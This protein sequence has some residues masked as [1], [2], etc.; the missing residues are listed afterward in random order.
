VRSHL[1]L[2]IPSTAWKPAI[3]ETQPDGPPKENAA[4]DSLAQ[5]GEG[6]VTLAPQ[7]YAALALS[8]PP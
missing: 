2:H 8:G 1:E 6:Q 7:S 3:C 5:G 4:P